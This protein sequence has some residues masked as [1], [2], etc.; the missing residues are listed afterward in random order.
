MKSAALAAAP[1]VL[2]GR[3][4]VFPDADTEY[5][6]RAI[7]LMDSTIVVDLL[8]QFRFPDFSE[9]PPR[10][11]RWLHQPDT[12]TPD[13]FAPYAASQISAFTLGQGADSYEQGVKLFADWNGFIAGYPGRLTRIGNVADFARAKRD[14]RAGIVL[15]MQ[16]SQHFRSPADVD[17]F[18]G[19]GQRLSQLS[20]NFS[21]GIGSGFLEEHDGG[22]TVFGLSI[23]QRMNEVGM[24]VDVSHCADRT[25]MD[26][27]NAST[28]PVVSRTR[29]AGRSCQDIS[30]ARRTRPSSVWR[31]PAAS[32]GFRSCDF[33]IATASR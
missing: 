8:N 31:R 19:L 21:N 30:A 3:F 5:S 32:W 23:V 33:S 28:K 6:S 9:T 29:T 7:R 24:A 25:T 1:A 17:T 14:G 16:D 27:L 12:F 4:R 10:I 18:W 13:D 26:A 11:N 20:Y 15:T 22:L 2:R